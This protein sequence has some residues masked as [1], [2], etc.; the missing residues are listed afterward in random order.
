MMSEETIEYSKKHLQ[1]ALKEAGLPSSRP[2]LLKYEVNGVID[3]PKRQAGF[4][5]MIWNFYTQD[6]IDECVGRVIAHTEGKDIC[7][8]KRHAART[9]TE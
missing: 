5:H 3:K 9:A 1:K 2:T 6:E 4:G 7:P 8:C